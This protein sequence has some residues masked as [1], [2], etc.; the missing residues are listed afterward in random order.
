MH[1]T[2]MNGRY[3]AILGKDILRELDLVI[4]FHA[5]TVCWNKSVIYM[6]PL[7]CM[8]ESLYFLNDTAKIAE[9]T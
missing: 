5:E 9:D 2:Q 7:G 3:N 6:K 4:D 8:Q 1:F